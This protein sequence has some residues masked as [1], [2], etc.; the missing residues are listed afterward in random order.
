MIAIKDI[1]PGT[2]GER[3]GFEP[4]DRI[5]RINGAAI[6]DLID[7]QVNSSEDVLTIEVE[8]A[9]EVYELE[10][11]RAEGESFAFLCC[12]ALG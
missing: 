11:D 2:L 8:R 7:F 9:E 12:R 5:L 4:G 6:D 10:V 1:E 3:A